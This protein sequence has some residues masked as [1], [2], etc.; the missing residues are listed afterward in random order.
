MRIE[1]A[2]K[3]GRFAMSTL[4]LWMCFTCCAGW[5]AQVGASDV[6]LESCTKELKEGKHTRINELKVS[7]H[8]HRAL[9]HLSLSCM[10][11]RLHGLCM[12]CKQVCHS[13][14]TAT[15]ITEL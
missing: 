3:R 10:V 11:R 14:I 8:P 4:H 9:L 7:T 2:D 15:P 6:D 13:Y 5:L 1:L 12:T